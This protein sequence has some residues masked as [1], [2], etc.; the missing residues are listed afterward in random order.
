MSETNRGGSLLPPWAEAICRLH[1]EESPT[2]SVKS[3]SVS[4]WPK[5][6]EEIGLLPQTIQATIQP[7]NSN[8]SPASEQVSSNIE[9][10]ASL[11]DG[12][13]TASEQ[14]ETTLA[15]RHRIG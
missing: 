13:V 7:S 10:I 12:N 5:T 15:R 4:I 1:R 6:T 9:R 8:A 14:T 11:I 3:T 2:C